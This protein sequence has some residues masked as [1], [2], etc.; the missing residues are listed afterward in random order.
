[1]EEAAKRWP[2]GLQLPQALACCPQG[3]EHYFSRLITS[4]GSQWVRS[5]QLGSSAL[6]LP[7]GLMDK[8]GFTDFLIQ[9]IFRIITVLG[10]ETQQG[11]GQSPYSL[12]NRLKAAKQPGRSTRLGGLEPESVSPDS[13]TL[14]AKEGNA[15]GPL[16]SNYICHSSVKKATAKCSNS[17]ICQFAL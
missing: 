4:Q 8:G 1:M 17:Q 7:C 3:W 2:P 6:S 13:T 16:L 12:E 9:Q 5:L 14:L 11:T 15:Q 10:T